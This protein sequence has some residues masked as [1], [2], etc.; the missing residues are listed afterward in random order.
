MATEEMCD[1]DSYSCNRFANLHVQELV[2]LE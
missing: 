1:D 2:L